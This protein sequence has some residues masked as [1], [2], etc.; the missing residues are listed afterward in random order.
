MSEVPLYLTAAAG[1]SRIA[2]SAFR[3][4]PRAQHRPHVLQSQPVRL[5]L[6]ERDWYF[7]AEQPA[8]APH[9][10]MDSIST[11][12]CTSNEASAVGLAEGHSPPPP[13]PGGGRRVVSIADE[14]K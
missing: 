2:T 9:P 11:Y 13:L 8:P 1:P 7:I 5:H 4:L 10:R 6:S 12:H 3:A 14:D